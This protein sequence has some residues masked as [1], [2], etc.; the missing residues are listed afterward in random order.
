MIEREDRNARSAMNNGRISSTAMV[1]KRTHKV[2]FM[3]VIVVRVLYIHTHIRA[4]G[5]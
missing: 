4:P 1:R 5:R 2:N 3:C